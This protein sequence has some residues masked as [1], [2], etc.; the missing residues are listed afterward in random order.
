MG[1]RYTTKYFR[2]VLIQN[3]HTIYAWNAEFMKLTGNYNCDK[4]RG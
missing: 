2:K 1:Y 3:F 4:G